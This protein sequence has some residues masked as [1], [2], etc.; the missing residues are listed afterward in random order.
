MEREIRHFIAEKATGARNL[1]RNC[2]DHQW[3]CGE[4]V[5]ASFFPCP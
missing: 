5:L 1:S 3:G 4:Q 2:F